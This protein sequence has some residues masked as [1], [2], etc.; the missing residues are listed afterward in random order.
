MALLS[1]VS[2]SPWSTAISLF[3]YNGC[4][5]IIGHSGLKLKVIPPEENFFIWCSG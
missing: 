1:V 4:N 2:S 5:G 3:D